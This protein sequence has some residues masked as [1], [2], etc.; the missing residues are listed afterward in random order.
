MN[1]RDVLKWFAACPLLRCEEKKSMASRVGWGGTKGRING[2][3][4]SVEKNLVIELPNIHHSYSVLTV[5]ANV[6]GV[7]AIINDPSHTTAGT[8][9]DLFQCGCRLL[10]CQGTTIAPSTDINVFG[11]PGNANV[12]PTDTGEVLAAYQR[13]DVLFDE[14]LIGLDTFHFEFPYAAMLT[15]QNKNLQIILT[16]PWTRIYDPNQDYSQIDLTISSL[17][18]YGSVYTPSDAQSRFFPKL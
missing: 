16:A 15:D 10:V 4:A 8:A 2:A 5:T 3:V 11:Y 1:R 9:A 13:G 6:S 17:A 12:V 14:V 7:N 18:A